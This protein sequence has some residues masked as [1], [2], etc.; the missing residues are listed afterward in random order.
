MHRASGVWPQSVHLFWTGWTA[1]GYFHFCKMKFSL[2]T[3]E[4]RKRRTCL[5]NWPCWHLTPLKYNP[6]TIA[7]SAFYLAHMCLEDSREWIL[8]LQE[9]TSYSVTELEACILMIWNTAMKQEKERRK[10]EQLQAIFFKYSRERKFSIPEIL[11]KFVEETVQSFVSDYLRQSDWSKDA[12]KVLFV[13][14][15]NY[16]KHP[17]IFL[18]VFYCRNTIF[19][20]KPR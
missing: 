9:N 17:Q 1:K 4:F 13:F 8:T 11:S 3:K 5:P 20:S 15:L 2:L 16:I 12:N 7:A 10:C 6:S 18:I 19:E 14:S